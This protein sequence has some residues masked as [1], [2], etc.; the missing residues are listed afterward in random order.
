MIKVLA[1]RLDQFKEITETQR[2]FDKDLA[3]STLE[4]MK[5]LLTKCDYLSNDAKKLPRY[6]RL[7]FREIL[8][9]GAIL[10]VRT[11]NDA[12]IQKLYQQLRFF[13]FE[14]EDLPKS[15]RMFSII[16]IN[17]LSCCCQ[18]LIV[19]FQADLIQVL[20][21]F[22]KIKQF[23]P[24]LQF[25]LDVE[26]A[27]TDSKLSLITELQETAPST[28][29]APFMERLVDHVRVQLTKNICSQCKIDLKGLVSILNMKDTEECEK[30][31]TAHE[32]NNFQE[33]VVV[34]V[35]TQTVPVSPS[36]KKLDIV[37]SSAMRF[38]SLL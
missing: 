30:F 31:L 27:I 1:N 22:G 25:I 32:W 4:E 15:Q 3:I 23:G 14:N 20:N 24:Y 37:L 35:D 16:T 33:Y 38:N 13:Y 19:E 9:L 10:A 29:F 34:P 2:S 5:I 18:G 21:K 36:I 26:Q 17:L 6:D 11:K 12:E 8:E 7:V 28:L